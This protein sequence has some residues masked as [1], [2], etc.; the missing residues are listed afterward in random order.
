MSCSINEYRCTG[1]HKLLF[2]GVLIEGELEIKCK[3]CHEI[4]RVSASMHNE[5][6]CLIPHCPHRISLPHPT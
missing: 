1:C 4:N 6:L 3:T 5:L 2:K